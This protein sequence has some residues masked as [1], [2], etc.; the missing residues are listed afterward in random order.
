LGAGGASGIGGSTT[1]SQTRDFTAEDFPAL[2][3]QGQ[4]GQ[5]RDVVAN[6]SAFNTLIVYGVFKGI[7]GIEQTQGQIRQNLLAS[8]G[9]TMQQGTPG[10]LNLSGTQ[11]RNVHP[12]FQQPTPD[13]EKQHQRERVRLFS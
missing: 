3:G 1:A 5:S 10:L 2:G 12:G 4:S 11:S 9:P 13:V 6:H 7:F 8:H